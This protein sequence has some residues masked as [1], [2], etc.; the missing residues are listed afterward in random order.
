MR[1]LS[2]DIASYVRWI[3][4][5]HFFKKEKENRGEAEG[6]EK[7]EGEEEENN[8]LLLL[9]E[10]KMESHFA[11]VELQLKQVLSLALQLVRQR[12]EE[13]KEKRSAPPT[14]LGQVGRSPSGCRWINHITSPRGETKKANPNPNLN[15]R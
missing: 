10:A 11:K 2:L 13:A 14:F 15:S 6:G 5:L 8:K 3:R 12:G 4:R 1:K 7:E 9:E